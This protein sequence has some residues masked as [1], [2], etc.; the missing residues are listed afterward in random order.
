MLC[1]VL[2]DVVKDRASIGVEFIVI[3]VCLDRGVMLLY[4]LH[5]VPHL[6]VVE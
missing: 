6:W 2:L 1:I 5:G 4:G 3:Q